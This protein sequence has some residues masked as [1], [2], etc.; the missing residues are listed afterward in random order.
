MGS[1]R[2]K[3]CFS[4]ND[5]D[6]HMF[7]VSCPALFSRHMDDFI[8]AVKQVEDGSPGSDPVAVVRMLRRAAGLDDAFIRHFLGNVDSNRPDMKANL[9]AYF[10]EAVPHRVT[11]SSE[12]EGVVLT[13]DGTTVALAP[14]LLGIE[15]GFLPKSAGRLRSLY[16]LTL[17]KDLVSSAVPQRLGPDGCWDSVTSPR[18]FTL[19]G[20]PSLLTTAQVNG[21][22]DGVLLGKEVVS[23]KP[24]R[25]V[26]IS[27]L[28]AEYYSRPLGSAGL[29][30]APPIISRRRRENFKRLLVDPQVLERQLVDPQVLERQLVDPQLKRVTNGRITGGNPESRT[31]W[32]QTTLFNAYGFEGVPTVADKRSNIK[33]SN[34]IKG[35]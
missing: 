3:T 9:S 31:S 23:A 18:V 28:L 26:K 33:R 15:A 25:P 8:E 24:R 11:G 29:D 20:R 2:L 19:L 12:E 22:V 7:P 13:P 32:I 34:P 35:I 5:E 1:L 30:A 17:G 14:L 4:L 6:I 16:Q 10:S 21:G 27:S